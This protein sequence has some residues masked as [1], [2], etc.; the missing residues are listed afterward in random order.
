MV[1]PVVDSGRN[2]DHRHHFDRNTVASH[3]CP[4]FDT[5]FGYPQGL[6]AYQMIGCEREP[7]GDGGAAYCCGMMYDQRKFTC[8]SCGEPL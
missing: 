3:V 7:E 6:A 8:A 5:D 2:T 1:D 4:N